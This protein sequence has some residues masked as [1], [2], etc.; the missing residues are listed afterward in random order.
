MPLNPGDTFFEYR[1]TR[2]LGRGAFGTV[3]LAQDTL[4]E[5]P[6]AIKELMIGNVWRSP[7]G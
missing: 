7:S 2:A 1:I 3:W 4:L 6:V 5:R